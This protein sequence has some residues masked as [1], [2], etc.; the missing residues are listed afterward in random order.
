MLT[1]SG[2]FLELFYDN[3]FRSSYK[4]DICHVCEETL[5]Y[6]TCHAFDFFS[7]CDWVFN[8]INIQVDNVVF[9][10]G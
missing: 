6:H 10:I 5:L 4:H 1:L 9:A 8:W 3:P 2:Y 7:K